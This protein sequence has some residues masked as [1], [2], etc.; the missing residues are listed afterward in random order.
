[1]GEEVS[2]TFDKLVAMKVEAKIIN[3]F[4][5]NG[6]GGNPAG[7]V[8]EAD[9]LTST[10]KQHIAALISLP[11]TAFVSR[12]QTAD[13]KLDFFTPLKQIPHCGHAT[14]AT[15]SWLKKTGHITKEYSS[16]ETIDGNRSI[17]FKNG[18]AFMEQKAPVMQV[19]VEDIPD[20][21]LS[22]HVG[23][24]DLKPGLLPTIINTGNSFLM[25]PLQNE[26]RLASINY[27][28]EMV[29]R[30][31]EKHNLVGFYVYAPSTE[32]G[33]DAAARMFG[34][35]YGIK[36]EAGTGMAAGPLACFLYEAENVRKENFRIQQG[37]FMQSPSP[38]LIEVIL[39]IED[40]KIAR[41][42][43]GGDAYVSGLKEI[44]LSENQGV[45]L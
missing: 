24:E 15:F 28:H 23:E 41:L 19:P 44:E 16:K 12:S 1:V 26:K 43:A 20:I 8:F 21:L 33:Y 2:N 31:S 37:R 34:P 4:S 30:I 35:F 39:E 11:E 32:P 25:V 18:L 9:K 10:G 36:E 7:V 40:E 3:A 42:Y 38:S 6:E 22:L 45:F 14:I 17:I 29:Y 27:D 5:I 13:Y